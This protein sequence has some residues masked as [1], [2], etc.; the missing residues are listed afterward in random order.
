MLLDEPTSAMDAWAEAE[1]LARLRKLSAG[2]TT[3]IIT[4]RLTTAMQADII[5][6]MANGQVIESGAHASLVAR[7]GRYAQAWLAQMRQ[8]QLA[9]GEG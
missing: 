1:W 7:N 5:H 9:G 6:V 8:T 4:H 3:L 2:R